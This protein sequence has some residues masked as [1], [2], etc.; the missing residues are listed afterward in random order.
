MF[1]SF[2][3]VL[4]ATI[5]LAGSIT[6]CSAD[7][8]PTRGMIRVKL[9]PEMVLQVGNAPRVESMGTLSTGVTPLDRAT[10]QVKATTLR[11]MLPY[12]PK[13]E[14][15]RAKYG[16]DRWYVVEFDESVDPAEARKVF[17]STAGVERSEVIVP[18]ALKEGT[19]EFIVAKAPAHRAPS[20]L[21]FND[22]MLSEQWHYKNFGNISTNVAGA[23]ANIF[24]AWKI[25]TGKPEVIVAIIDGG[26][27]YTH[28]DLAPNMCINE[29]ELNGQPGVDDDGNG[30]VDDIY[31]YNFCTNS[32]EVYPHSHGTHVA[33]T[34]AAVN[35]NGIGVSGVAGG[36]GDPNTGVRMISCQVFDS[37]TGS[38]DGDFAKAII[39]AAERGATIAQ[40]SWGWSS[41]DYYEQAVLDAIDYFTEAARSSTM[42]GGLCIFAA[43]NDGQTGNYYPAC[44]E[45]VLAVGAMTGELTPA[46]YSNY[47]SWIDIMAPGGHLDYNTAQGVLSTLPNNSYGYNEGT[48]M[49]TPHVSGIA[50]LVLSQYGST[51]FINET[52]R[53]Q[54]LTSVNDFYGYGDNS[55]Y[56]GLY[57]AG[58]IDAAKAL[59]M[60][61]GDAPDAVTDLSIDAA[62]DYLSLSWTIPAS[63]DNNVNNHIIY[64]STEP[65]TAS[66]DI[67]KLQS[68]TVD[69][70]FANSGD[71]FTYELTGLKS[72]TDYYVAV[73]AVNRWGQ[74]SAM[75]AV[76]HATTNAGPVMVVDQNDISMESTANIPV[77]KG[78]F[79]IG[80][81][82][83]GILKWSVAKRTVSVRPM[84]VSRPVMLNTKPYSGKIDGNR[85][86]THATV[87]ADYEASD[88]P[89]DIKTYNILWAYIGDTDRTLPNSMAQ[90]FKVDPQQ[91]PDGFNLTHL[92][93]EGANGSQPRIEIYKG[94]VTISAAS[95]IADVNYQYFV[96]N[97]NIAL[98]EQLFF[99][100]GESFWVAVHFDG[101]QEGYPLGL[102]DADADGASN[103]SYMSNDNGKSWTPLT[104][105][106]AGS[107]YEALGTKCAW[108]ISARSLNPDWSRMMELN[109]T[110][111]DV[112]SGEL[113]SVEV[114]VDGRSLVNGDYK[115]KVLV[116]GNETGGDVQ[117]VPVS[118]NVN[119]NTPDVVL[120]KVVDFG[121]LLVGQTKTL[122]VE[123]YNRGYGS[124]RGSAWGA[125]LYDNNISSSNANFKG[126]DYLQ[127]GFPARTSTKVDITFAPVEAGVHSG[128]VVFT[129]A[130]GVQAKVIVQGSA[131]EPAKLAIEPVVIDAGT[132][133][134]GEEP[135]VKK[136]SIKNEGKYPLEYVFP[137]F[138][139]ESIEGATAASH[140]Y[141]YTVQSNIEG[142][143]P[144]EYDGNPDLIGATD[145]SSKFDD[146][147][148]V[149]DAISLGF[150]FPYYGKTYSKVYVTSFGGLM[151]APNEGMF[152]SPLTP[153]FAA[154]AGTGLISAYGSQLVMNPRSRVE[155]AKQDGKF[156][157]KFIDVLATVYD[158]EKIPISFHLTLSANGDIEIFY[159]NYDPISVF[160]NGSTLFCGINDPE[161]SDV[162]TITCADMADYW[163]S[164]D[165]TPDNSRFR[166]F[167]SGTAVRFEAPKP[168]FVKSLSQASGLVLPG[169]SVEVEATLAADATMYAGSTFNNLA[170]VTNDPKPALSFVRFDAVIA[171]DDLVAVAALESDNYNFGKVFRTSTM[172]IPVTVKNT[173]NDAMTIISAATDGDKFSINA[174]LPVTVPAGVSKDIIIVVPTD[175]E[176][177]LSDVLTVET[178]V[179]TLNAVIEGEVI[180]CPGI[181]LDIDAVTETVA[182]GT[183]LSKTL[184]VVNDGNEALTYSV[185]PNE[186]IALT[187]PERSESKTG[188]T[189]SSSLD[190]EA[191]K[192]DWIDIETTGLGTQL[193]QNYYLQHDYFEV[194]LP[195]EFPFYGK[196]YSKIY[197]YN[198]GFVSFTYRHDNNMFPEPPANFPEG[199]V[200]NNM[201]APYWG[202]HTMDQTRT[203][204]TYHYVT[205]DR[206][207]ISFMEYGNSMNFGVCYQLIMEK[208]GKFK[209]Q[210][211]G[212]DE[213]AVIFSIF[214]LAGICN[215]DYSQSVRL[216]ERMVM[217][218][219]AV[220]FKPVV[221]LTLQP[222]SSDEIGIDFDTKKMAGVYNTN[223]EVSSNVPGKEK[224]EIPV[225][226]TITGTP[227]LVWPGDVTVEHTI[228]YNSTD[229]TDPA[230]MMGAGPY[231]AQFVI[232]N[233]GTA[234]ITITGVEVDGPVIVDDDPIWGGTFPVFEYLLAYMPETNMWTGE[235]TGNMAWS[236]YYQDPLAVAETPVQFAIPMTMNPEYCGVPGE[237][238]LPVTIH[239]M[240]A[241]GNESTHKFNVKFVVTDCPVAELDK[242]EIYV[243]AA[244]D[245]HVADEAVSLSN[246]GEY[247]M[248]YSVYIDPT[249]VGEQPDE[250]DGGG[251]IAPWSNAITD[252]NRPVLASRL[253]SKVKPLD[254][255]DDAF[256]CPQNFEYLDALYY[257]AGLN[258]VAYNYGAGTL[259]DRY[260]A[261]TYFKA[262]AEGFNISHIYSAVTIETATNIDIIV[263]VVA[264]DNPDGT[265][266][267]KGKLHIAEQENPSAG[268]NYIIK[269][270]HSVYMNPGESFFVVMTYPAGVKYPAYLVPKEEG[271][272][273]SRYLGWTEGYGWYDVAA[274]FEDQYGSLGYIMTCIETV[275]G[276]TWVKLLNPESEGSIEPGEKVD[277]NIRLS[278]AS[279]RL[280]KDNKAML[281]IKTNDPDAAVIN[282]PITL[283][284]NGY[285]IV[286]GAEGM[287]YAREGETTKVA[288]SVLE[289]DLDDYELRF[290]DA[291]GIAAVESV[292]AAQ[293]DAA[294]ITAVEGETGVY[295]VSGATEPVTVNVAIAPDYGMAGTGYAFTVTAKDAVGHETEYTG[296]YNV[297][298]VNR[299]PEAA[300]VEAI[301]V[302][303][304]QVSAPVDFTALFSDPDDDV[305]SY[306][307][308]FAANDIADAYTTPTGVLFVGKKEG[309]VTATVTATDPSGASTPLQLT[310][311]VSEG[312]GIDEVTAD[313][314]E[315]IY[316]NLQGI[317]VINPEP[318][319]YLV[320][321]GLTVTK[322]YVR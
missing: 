98:D 271:Y 138:S 139:D 196:K 167:G 148:Y 77:A 132:L 199:S 195:F 254:K 76:M 186:L 262:P 265:V 107:V 92:Y 103:G 235:P 150:D 241:E 115:F 314:G 153:D 85:I 81:E 313:D 316:Y 144:C 6:L 118:L 321:R 154:I 116:S 279:A 250:P 261:A 307:F 152:R 317:R 8:K 224:V 175:E 136:F 119:G 260:K 185:S 140:R 204:G 174:E 143:T 312:A 222:D 68:R 292:V 55:Q 80:N 54:L 93:I 60:G 134:V 72:L 11:R 216:P 15:Q 299:A 287:I 41:P 122:T 46:S 156:V 17:A 7:S 111:G 256:D 269:L 180:G 200:Y 117:G 296:R 5:V 96:Y 66:T 57:G 109:P 184:T 281:V 304:G 233:E 207:I 286:E 251:G 135:V 67:S 225:E 318:G 252:E 97:Y 90:W 272:I 181:T 210:Y 158:T 255:S 110:S 9:Q 48:S 232:A 188:Y 32:S 291:A 308:E 211:K 123:A 23:D 49:A 121:S 275:K 226:L 170:I 209:F 223:I 212:F 198:T 221:E 244:S 58:Y 31:G 315:V 87:N 101:N 266:V 34:V 203:A 320:K 160:Q 25:T 163:G 142:Y 69:T 20:A 59:T 201:I 45:K 253:T 242:A 120:P 71:R 130:N 16:L 248:D 82:G 202:L 228:N 1:N 19:G 229:M 191:V 21:P 193:S 75:S 63:D 47:G 4:L 78:S 24:E 166:L 276:E 37:R 105:A 53:T 131:T 27:D 149:S 44:Y 33:G 26:V 267:A 290:A 268:Q 3:R 10:K 146:S 280:E 319:Y 137:R 108:A 125:G 112:R 2:R 303:I 206:A 89:Q 189:Y 61:N 169:E 264:G 237:H 258:K 310:I 217:F 151:F 91:F 171:G 52:L 249:G 277:F 147:N 39:Y 259:Y 297:E 74:A 100:P 42:T 247:R 182:S 86:V 128:T 192:Y 113:Q 124:F 99:A 270:D 159:D 141:G 62:Q 64:F 161:L 157:V 13:F 205:E 172:R 263:E 155:Y 187:V 240:D 298:H 162:L 238:N 127:Q 239:W 179:G 65:F 176:G 18:M 40:C 38:G 295:T 218:N 50:A 173:G 283:D 165:P 14:A 88:Y 301:E 305:L 70:K 133:T 145:L 178:S 274:V 243:K 213:N 273:D 294:V 197:I 79:T 309:T 227:S 35:N 51:S 231:S 29:A 94:D 104:Q 194:E 236:V 168:M 22:P 285:P 215:D 219:Q 95:K 83:E 300:A 230:V 73:V 36:N 289:P 245:D 102:G 293:G 129:D 288:V 234:A 28:D 311:N 306:D 190:D 220:Q 246:T 284:K 30:Y 183:P 106:L 278:A 302:G 322:E 257:P 282:F 84:N 114:S 214:G 208:D 56:R 126:P 43:G 164:E 12:A 177:I